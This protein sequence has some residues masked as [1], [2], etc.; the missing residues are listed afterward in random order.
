MVLKV[1]SHDLVSASMNNFDE[2]FISDFKECQSR[3]EDVYGMLNNANA[4]V[5]R[6]H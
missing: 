2:S 5:F 4:Q 6:L 1:S 3:L